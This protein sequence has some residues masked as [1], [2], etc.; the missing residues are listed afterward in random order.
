LITVHDGEA[1][2]IFPSYNLTV[3][4]ENWWKN[5]WFENWNWRI[6]K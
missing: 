6:E 2:L 4:L 5:E 1:F 3:G